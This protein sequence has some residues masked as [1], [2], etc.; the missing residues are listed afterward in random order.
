MTVP[1]HDVDGIPAV[2]DWLPGPEARR[3]FVN[4]YRAC[5]QRNDWEPVYTGI[6]GVLAAAA[7]RHIQLQREM[8]VLDPGS[9]TPEIRA[10][11]AETRSVARRAMAAMLLIP[12]T[13]IDG[14]VIRPDGVDEDVA[15]ICDEP[16]V[17]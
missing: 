2:P 10:L 3:A 7:G 17:Q 15:R 14:G 11:A 1:G 4:G 8:A 9:I 6:L 5:V 13:N 12:E 16:L